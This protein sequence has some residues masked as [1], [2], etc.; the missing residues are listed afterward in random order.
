MKPSLHF[1]FLLLLFL[2]LHSCASYKTF[3]NVQQRNVENS[4]KKHAGL[5]HTTFLIGDAGGSDIGDVAPA[6]RALRPHLEKAGKK[7]SVFILG[8]NIYPDGLVGKNDPNRANAEH[9]L[10]VQLDVLKDYRGKAIVIPGN[11]DWHRGLK[12]IK[13]QEKF[14]REYLDDKNAFL[15]KN[16]CAGPEVVKLSDQVIAIVIDSEWWLRDWDKEPTINADCDVTTRE[17]LINAYTDILKKNRTKDIV[18][19]F[20]HPL[21]TYGVHGGYYTF[22]DHLFPLTALSPNLYIPL[23]VIG[24]L[25]PLL[26]GNAGVKQDLQYQAFVDFKSQILHASNG[27]ENLIFVAGHEH[28]LQYIVDDH[29]FIVSGSGSKSTALH[30]GRS[31][32]FGSTDQGFVALY[33]YDDG[34]SRCRFY[35]A[36]PDGSAKIIFESEIQGPDQDLVGKD[37]SEFEPLPDTVSSSIYDE[38]F[39]QKSGFYKQFWGHWYR[40]MYSQEVTVPTLDLSSSYGGLKPVRRGGG[41][42]TSSLRLKNKDGNEYAIRAMAKNA[43][44]LL[45]SAFQNT[46][47][48]DLMRDFF[49]TAHPYAAFVIP[50]MADAIDVFHANP[51]LYY[52]PKQPALGR[53][54]DAFG[55]ELYLV[56]ERAAGDWRNLK[57]F[58]NSKD[59][60][61]TVDLLQKLQQSDKHRLDK[62][63]IIRSRL[64]DLVIKD[65]DRHQDQW[66]WAS[67]KDKKKD[68]TMYRPIPRDRDQAFSN[69][70]GLFTGFATKTLIDLRKMQRFTPDTKKVH[71]LTWGSRFFDRRFLN[72]A[73]W[74]EWEPQIA[75]IQDRLTDQ[76]IDDALAQWPENIYNIDGPKINKILKQRRN[77]LDKM[78]GRMYKFLARNVDIVGTK[79]EDYFLVERLG[80]DLVTVSVYRNNDR[81]KKDR[82]YHRTFLSEE[83]KEISIYGLDDGDYFEV[84]GD[85]ENKIKVR[86]IGG[87]G[88]DHFVEKSTQNPDSKNVLVYDDL[89]NNTLKLGPDSKD[90][91]SN[92]RIENEYHFREFQYNYTLALPYAALLS[93]DGFFLGGFLT[94]QV[95]SF[96]KQ[97]YGQSHTFGINYAFATQAFQFSWKGRFVDAVGRWDYM[98]SVLY[99]TPRYS[100]NFYGL[101]NETKSENDN[102]FYRVRNKIF[103]ITSGFRKHYQGGSSLEFKPSFEQIRLENTDNR[104]ISTISNTLRPDIFTNQAYGGIDIE[105]NH[106]SKSNL[107]YPTR[108]M[109]FNGSVG[110]KK[111]LSVS[112]RSFIKLNQDLIF[113]IPLDKR[114]LIVFAT[115]FSSNQI[116]GDFDFYH[117]VMIGGLNTLRG[118]RPER[119]NGRAS[120]AHSSDL[121]IPLVKVRN[122]I[123]PFAIGL[124]AS[125]DHGRV[126]SDTSLGNWH[127]SYGGSLWINMVN[128]AVIRAGWHRSIDGNRFLVALGYAF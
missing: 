20:H 45:P 46:F 96:K 111:N 66:R 65:W 60:I 84:V 61:S 109:I 70:D 103:R 14:V 29:P 78:A 43:R 107:A 34:S 81:E 95:A 105:F 90:M 123:I 2:L 86:L 35:S 93:D 64:F 114:E 99:Q 110:W 112:D 39:T 27:F 101:G 63:Y 31:L 80:K 16:G 40:D 15:P 33:F 38:D 10:K 94:H 51:K 98:P 75:L 127:T 113:Y 41:M 121:R 4:E 118:L 32:L 104:F 42:Q 21:F 72:E 119:L 108:G 117:G 106:E 58:G 88:K 97:P 100:F 76:V 128:A 44:N 26:R 83:T 52:I 59:I 67:K 57:S 49:T 54:N 116:Y 17:E 69:F 122:N 7:S 120:M 24:S 37:L 92:R 55:N 22:K 48:S 82:I 91:R 9:A 25:Y 1:V 13:R 125:F 68:V 18:V 115:K 79:K 47:V 50:K 77:N 36:N 23:P 53:Y 71:W 56:E 3:N 30:N 28:N 11:H 6:L 89:R 124:T 126:Y 102:D 62:D 87:Q 85:P 74:E 8:D 19:A 73:S 12:G 5:V